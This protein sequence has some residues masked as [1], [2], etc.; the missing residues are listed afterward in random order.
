MCYFYQILLAATPD[1]LRS[2]AL[3]AVLGTAPGLLSSQL[4]PFV[5]P[6]CAKIGE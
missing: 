4:A 1:I 2:R 6:E 3:G 5:D